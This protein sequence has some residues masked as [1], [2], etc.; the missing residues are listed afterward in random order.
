MGKYRLINKSAKEVVDVQELTDMEEAKEF[1]YLKKQF[2]S[3]EDFDKL[4]E[5]KSE[6]KEKKETPQF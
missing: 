2:S 1:F 4:Y 6:N 3:K 5:V